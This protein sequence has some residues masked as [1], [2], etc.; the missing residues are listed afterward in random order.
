MHAVDAWLDGVDAHPA[1]WEVTSKHDLPG[2]WKKLGAGNSKEVSAASYGAAKVVVKTKIAS[3]RGAADA[4]KRERD[5]RGELLY[6]E[7]LAGAPG[8]PKLYGGWLSD[9]GQRVTY[10][11]QNAGE[12]LGTGT[13]KVARPAK[14]TKYWS[15]LCRNEPLAATRALLECFR[16]FSELGGYFLD[17]FSP[18]QFTVK[19]RAVYLV[20]G[21]LALTGAMRNVSLAE[22]LPAYLYGRGKASA[23]PCAS[24]ADCSHTSTYH[25]CCQPKKSG[26]KCERGNEGAP[27]AKGRCLK[28]KPTRTCAPISTKTHVFDVA[29]KAWALPYVVKEGGKKLTP[30]AKRGLQRLIGAMKSK[31][32][33]ARPNFTEALLSLDNLG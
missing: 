23:G 24:D 26:D 31:E 13:G 7:F 11:V 3:T 15:S 9:G 30:A 17:D 25:C 4:L 18:H 20:D 12:V 19:S 8:I 27:E 6:L 1:H 21:P 22:H 33:E 16:S 14:P 29:A 5:L 32:P 2:R 10:V 28:T